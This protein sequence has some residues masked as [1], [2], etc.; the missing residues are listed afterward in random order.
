MPWSPLSFRRGPR[1]RRGSGARCADREL[2]RL[3]GA[4]IRRGS[5]PGRRRG[6]PGGRTRAPGHAHRRLRARR[7]GAVGRAHHPRGRRPGRDRVRARPRRPGRRHRP[8]GDLSARGRRQ[9]RDRLPASAARPSRSS[10]SR[11]PSCSPPTPRAPPRSST[12]SRAGAHRLHRRARRPRRAGRKDPGGRR[13]ARRS[14]P[15]R[16]ARAADAERDRR[17]GRIRARG[18]RRSCRVA[19]LYL[20]GDRVQQIFGPGSGIHVLLDAA[21]VVDV[22]ELLGVDDN[23]PITVEA[24]IRERPEVPHRDHDRPR[25]GRRH[26]QIAGA[27]RRWRTPGRPN[28]HVLA[29]EDQY[30]SASVPAPANCSPS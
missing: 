13:G 7:R 8:F 15:R 30:L 1:L 17:R 28:R 21:G 29:Y 14:R 20:R 12:R 2:W 25:V 16:A 24:F 22:G 23:Q 4:Q 3:D 10:R 18:S 5:R 19:A 9:A 6:G 11:R 26:R 27:C